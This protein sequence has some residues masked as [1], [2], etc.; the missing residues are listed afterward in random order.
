[1]MERKKIN[2]LLIL[3]GWTMLWVVLGHSPLTMDESMP[4]FAKVIF[5]I[6]YSFH[7]PLFILISGYLFYLTR[8]YSRASQNIESMKKWSYSAIILDKL[9]RLGIPFIVF[10]I[11]AMAMKVLFPDN[12]ARSSSFSIGEFVHAILYPREG[13][14]LE[15]WFVAVIMWMFVLTPLWEWSFKSIPRTIAIAL[16]LLLLNLGTKYLPLGTF[17]CLRDTA[18]FGIYFY[19]G[20]LACKYGTDTI[21]KAYRYRILLIAALCYVGCIVVNFELGTA[22]SGIAFSVCLAFILDQHAPKS[23]SSFRNY[24]YQIFLIGI[25]AQIMIKMIYKRVSFMDIAL[26]NPTLIYVAF[27]LICLI[28]GLYVPI[29]V[30]K[31]AEKINWSPILV[32]IGLKK[33]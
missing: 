1:M 30:S 16:I 19:L 4:Q 6:A 32:S 25:F 3:Q 8:L 5:T 13:P 20:M 2:W 9:K 15:M 14:L 26:H 23:F 28:L 29:I 24:T 27:F 11:I 10:T 31:I 21:Y 33:K 22:L 18:K 7:M 17:L 12:M